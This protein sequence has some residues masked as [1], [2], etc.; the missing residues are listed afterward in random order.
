MI[1]KTLVGYALLNYYSKEGKTI[2]DAYVPLI[3]SCLIESQFETASRDDIKRMLNDIYGFEIITLGAID[4]IMQIMVKDNLLKKD[5]G[6]YWFD[7]NELV[8]YEAS[9]KQD[10]LLP[11][12]DSI[13]AKIR[14]FA[15]EHFNLSFENEEIEKCFL[16]FLQ[17][18]DMEIALSDEHVYAVISKRKPD[19]TCKYVI[20]RF[21][22]EAKESSP[23]IINDVTAF[24]KGH[25]M[26]SVVSLDNFDNY[27][28]KLDRV[29]VALDSPIIFNMLGLNGASNQALTDEL[30]SILNEKKASFLIFQQNYDEVISTLN[31]AEWRLRTHSFEY[32]KSSRVLKFACREHK[33]ADYIRLKI[34]QVDQ[35]LDDHNIVIS[36][37]PSFSEGYQEINIDLLSNTIK[38]RYTH[39]GEKELKEYQEDLINTDVDTI[40]YVFRLRGK[41][42]AINL[43]KCSA[44]LLTTNKAIAYAS[45]HPGLS[46]IRHTIP[47]CVTDVFLST[48]LWANFPQKNTDINEKLL[49]S[50]CY[51]SVLLDDDILRAFYKDIQK[52]NDENRITK[53]Q[54]ALVLSSNLTIS[55]L[56]QKTYNDFERYS[57]STPDEIVREIEEESNK[58]NRYL[59]N[60]L[61]RHD[62]KYR[63]ISRVL[64][65]VVYYTAWVIIAGLFIW[66]KF[67]DLNALIGWKSIIAYV[68]LLLSVLWGLLTN[69]GVI[70]PKKNIIIWMERILYDKIS[71][72]FERE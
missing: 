34:Q 64:S 65:S 31:D 50:D 21:L 37:A 54:V 66:I 15:K 1:D 70:R 14:A 27:G 28:G 24:A 39:N 19:K 8:K 59:T 33:N 45:R 58:E 7:R 68:I 20:S 26:A 67:I 13:V 25:S 56:E 6:S 5:R 60:R 52:M 44:V 46:L 35:L 49:M 43:K 51:S 36:N 16:S 29:R 9:K 38:N 3:V 23:E 40:S 41:T 2:L 11:R 18:H 10:N 32:E 57:D 4:S 42:P 48:L 55:L 17:Q 12:F 72:Y 61:N 62:E 53:E 69:I 47:A 22:L 30:I 71:A 63:K